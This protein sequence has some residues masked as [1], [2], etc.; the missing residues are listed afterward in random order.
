MY[1]YVWGIASV[2]PLRY[3]QHSNYSILEKSHMEFSFQ[4][5]CIVIFFAIRV[6]ATGVSYYV[7]QLQYVRYSMC[8]LT[9]RIMLLIACRHT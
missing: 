1:G 2:R 3:G 5:R 6:I 7:L 4:C 9:K 8:E